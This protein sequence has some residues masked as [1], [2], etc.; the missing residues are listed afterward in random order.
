M[1]LK[2]ALEI[3]LGLAE[4]NILSLDQEAEDYMERAIIE[5]SQAQQEALKTVRAHWRDLP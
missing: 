4:D 3:V 5:A 1:K 2:D